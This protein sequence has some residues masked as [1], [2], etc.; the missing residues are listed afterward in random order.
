MKRHQ[1]LIALTLSL[2]TTLAALPAA[3]QQT[4]SDKAWQQVSR[5]IEEGL[6]CHDQIDMHNP[7]I[8]QLFQFVSQDCEVNTYHAV[9]PKSFTVLGLP[10]TEITLRITPDNNGVYEFITPTPEQL[11]H[12]AI[13]KRHAQDQR[14][15]VT[16]S[17]FCAD[18]LCGLTVNP[19]ENAPSL[20]SVECTSMGY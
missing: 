7:T 16:M 14:A 12:D 9:P 13:A 4:G 19:I 11:I 1:L 10:V 20:R 2:I 5:Q 17:D 6:S 15:H 18:W 8:A 3:A